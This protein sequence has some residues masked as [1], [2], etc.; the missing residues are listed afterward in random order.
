MSSGQ[1]SPAAIQQE[2]DTIQKDIQNLQTIRNSLY[3]N[4]YSNA[5]LTTDQKQK[6]Q[7][8]IKGIEDAYVD[9][10]NTYVRLSGIVNYVLDSAQS[11]I[12]T[13]QTA[14]EIINSELGNSQR[15]LNDLQNDNQQKVRKIQINDYFAQKYQEHTSIMVII[16]SVL[17]IFIILTII[18]QYGLFFGNDSVYYFLVFVIGVYALYSILSKMYYLYILNNMVYGQYD[19]QYP[20]LSIGMDV[21]GTISNP[22]NGPEIPTLGCIGQECCTGTDVY[23]YDPDAGF[24]RCLPASSHVTPP[25]LSYYTLTKADLGA[26][27]N[28]SIGS[29][30]SNKAVVASNPFDPVNPMI[31]LT[32]GGGVT[33]PFSLKQG[34]Q[35]IY[36]YSGQSSSQ[37]GVN[38]KVAVYKPASGKTVVY[39]IGPNNAIIDK[40]M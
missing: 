19:Y 3:T 30:Q 33:L 22:W 36:E 40:V 24:N 5:S 17:V 13:Q 27:F 38:N 6:I 34:S 26:E 14:T 7:S 18:K 11:A 9:L 23:D 37:S 31:N 16:I 25:Q 35:G 12:L 39:I 28:S 8:Q 21:Q 4:L 2:L 29:G 32:I 1:N 10:Q 15:K 20:G